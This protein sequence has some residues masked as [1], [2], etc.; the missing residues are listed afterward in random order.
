MDLFGDIASIDEII[1]S[2]DGGEGSN[3]YGALKQ[4][5]SEQKEPAKSNYSKSC[6]YSVHIAF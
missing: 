4:S 3:P 6:L 5:V 2:H 1:L